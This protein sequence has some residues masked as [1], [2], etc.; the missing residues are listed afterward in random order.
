M[1]KPSSGL[2]LIICL[3]QKIYVVLTLKSY[4]LTTLINAKWTFTPVHLEIGEFI[5][6]E[7]PTLYW[8][9]LESL[10]SLQTEISD[11]GEE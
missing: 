2:L 4:P 7:S 5:A 8:D 6:D 9:Y 3:L 1:K 10:N 11:L